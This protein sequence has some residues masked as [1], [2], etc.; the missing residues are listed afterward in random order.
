MNSLRGARPSSARIPESL[1]SAANQQRN[2]PCHEQPLSRGADRRTLLPRSGR[3][4]TSSTASTAVD[5][6]VHH[7]DQWLFGAG[8]D[9][10]MADGLRISRPDIRGDHGITEPPSDDQDMRDSYD[11]TLFYTMLRDEPDQK[12]TDSLE[13]MLDSGMPIFVMHHALLN[14]GVGGLWS[15]GDRHA[16]PAD[17]GRRHLGEHL[18][19]AGQLSIIRQPPDS[20]TSRSRTRPM[21]SPTAGTTATCS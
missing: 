20:R 16:R 18:R 9:S 7:F 17:R 12:T 6:Y 14:W 10:F 11:V 4:S 13:R 1:P 5:A 21:P 19:G 3:S 2:G 8:N 15:R